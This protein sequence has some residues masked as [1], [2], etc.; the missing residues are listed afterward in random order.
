M[1]AIAEPLLPVMGEY[2]CSNHLIGDHD[3]L[4][5]AWARDGYWFFRDV[6][7]RHAIAD[8]RQVYM[9][10]LGEAG[11]A[12]PADPE[13]R[14]NGADVEGRAIHHLET[15]LSERRIDRMIHD[16]PRI[17]A[18]FDTLFGCAPCWI[19]FTSH[20][21]VAPEPDR[22]KRRL[23]FIHQDATYNDGLDFMV[24]W[25][26][27]AEIDEDIGGLALI[28]GVHCNGDLHRHEG[29]KILPIPEA[30]VAMASWK[31]THYRP[32]DVLLMDPGT[33]HSGVRNHSDRFRLSMDTRV[34][35]SN[36]NIPVMGTVEAADVDGILLNIGAEQ[37]RFRFDDRSFVRGQKGDQM[38]LSD[39]PARY[40]RGIEVIATTDGDTIR[41][42]RPLR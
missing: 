8:V 24:C 20:R 12:D 18:F 10:F 32:G 38:P 42:L 35:P 6:L 22:T 30:E 40:G 39:V 26:P 11:V 29:M 15:P 37:R 2:H 13:G 9:D 23:E 41:N 17:N 7:D 25:I 36:G 21:H 1:S 33:P 34:I 3:A 27:L 28:E 5:A 31:R 16:H 4:R 19:P 14:Y